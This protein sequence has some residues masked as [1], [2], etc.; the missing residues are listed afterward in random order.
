MI[1]RIDAFS[2]WKE[3]FLEV[4]GDVLQ[5]LNYFVKEQKQW[6]TSGSPVRLSSAIQG[7]VAD[8]RYFDC[9]F[10]LR[11]SRHRHCNACL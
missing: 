7:S 6:I 1:S 4:R 8:G 11:Y 10:W 3:E 5:M 2:R 9:Y